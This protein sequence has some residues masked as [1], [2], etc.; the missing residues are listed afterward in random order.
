MPNQEMKR[1]LLHYRLDPLTFL[2]NLFRFLLHSLVIAGYSVSLYRVGRLAGALLGGCC[3]KPAWVAGAC[4]K[5]VAA[6]DGEVAVS[7][8]LEARV[9]L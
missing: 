1:Y 5:L 9:T 8:I 7:R 3:R 6:T 2:V 4:G